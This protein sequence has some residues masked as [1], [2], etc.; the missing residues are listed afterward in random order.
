MTTS[1]GRGL[2]VGHPAQG[3]SSPRDWVEDGGRED[4]PPAPV[5]YEMMGSTGRGLGH[6][7]DAHA[8][9][10]SNTPHMHHRFPKTIAS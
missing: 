9:G 4:K 10:R 3:L 6:L 5:D 2:F 1:E 7:S 8:I